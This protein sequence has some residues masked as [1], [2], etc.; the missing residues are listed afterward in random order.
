MWQNMLFVVL[1][2]S[3]VEEKNTA[4]E[5]SE[6]FFLDIQ[7][8]A[9]SFDL[10]QNRALADIR[11]LSNQSEVAL[12][13]DTL[14]IIQVKSNG[15]S[16]SF[17]QED[18]LLWLDVE[19]NT[20]QSFQITYSFLDRDL[21]DFD[22]WMPDQGITFIWPY[23]C[24]N[25]YPCNPDTRDGISFSVDVQLAEGDARTVVAPSH[26]IP[27]APPYMPA[28]AVGDYTEL[29]V[30]TSQSGIEVY[31]WYLDGDDGLEDAEYGVLNMVESLNFMEETYGSYP[32]GDVLGTVEVDWG[33][34]SYG[35]MEHHPFFHVGMYDFWNEEAQIHE[36]AHAWYGD[37]VRL[38]CWEDFVLS[39]G[40]VT[41][42]TAKT[43]QE[44]AGYDL[45]AYYVEDFLDAICAGE[46]YN[47]VVLPE[48]CNDIDFENDDL[49]SLATYM[50]GACFYEEVG[51]IVGE[52]VVD[53][54]ISEFYQ[55]HQ[56]TSATM[57]EMIDLIHEYASPEQRE[58][59]N[60]A[61]QDWLLQYD[62]PTDY[63]QRCLYRNSQ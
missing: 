55:E 2:L 17:V 4:K 1:S 47:T 12:Q 32:F 37:A 38:E 29:F 34:D 18:G 56:Y 53:S 62:C 25:L 7:E 24:G 10:S 14:D 57:E 16:I 41:Y 6:E 60:T 42:I 39:E 40:T 52:D 48:G 11:L 61:V 26:H 36:L 19:P 45:W 5:T 28:F 33:D 13:A 8:V 20:D 58:S 21:Y 49:W 44:V 30:G 43:L 3:C 23:Y 51:D 54:I 22:G 59:I 27:E 31:A 63:A 9:L 46:D 50:K 35:G 15:D